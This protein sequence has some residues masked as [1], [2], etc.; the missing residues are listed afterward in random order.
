MRYHNRLLV[1]GLVVAGLQLSACQQH[2]GAHQ[3]EHPALVERKDGDEFSRVTLSERAIQRIGLK[4]DQVRDAKVARQ[5]IVGG[6]VVAPPAAAAA[7]R[8]KAWVRVRIDEDDLIRV[9][10]TQPAR[11]LPAARDAGGAGVTAQPVV[12]SREERDAGGAG[13]TTQPVVMPRE[14]GKRGVIP[15][16]ETVA[17]HFVVNV[18][19]HGLV[20][21]QRVRVEL[22]QSGK[23]PKR[24]VV[25][26]SA[27]I[28]D[29]KGQTW[30]YTSPQPRTF[31][32]H[33]VVVEY[34]QGEEA[35][36][37]DGPP[38]GTVVAS[39]AVA[40]LYGTET[41]VGH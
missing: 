7:D 14:Q 9:D 2:G 15:K 18:P 41:K 21:G 29:P 12:M 3:A 25:P 11:V 17:L 10:R 23:R 39:V 35:V 37:R 33:K 1:P 38:A 27:L 8:S 13:V 5:W 26:Y 22:P 19:G 31:I 24:Q 40:E 30:V 28:Y 34:I 32:R 20:P 16:D 6:E 4:T 36:L